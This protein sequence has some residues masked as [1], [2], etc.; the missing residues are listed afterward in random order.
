MI[1]FE[2]F[3]KGKENEIIYQCEELFDMLTREV[4]GEIIVHRPSG[5]DITNICRAWVEEIM[6][7]KWD[8]EVFESA[9]KSY[10]AAAGM[11]RCEDCG[12]YLTYK[13]AF[14]HCDC[15]NSNPR[16]FGMNIN[17]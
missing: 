7:I 1:N 14:V 11:E 13:G 6:P 15:D 8:V 16:Q 9:L 5:R 10:P 4:R 3:D 17:K 12:N 2:S